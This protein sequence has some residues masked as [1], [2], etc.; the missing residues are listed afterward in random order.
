[1]LFYFAR[2]HIERDLP[3]LIPV[4]KLAQLFG[5]RVVKRERHV[6]AF[7]E[8][9]R[10]MTATT[11]PKGGRKNADV[12]MSERC[13]TLAA[14][15]E[16]LDGSTPLLQLDDGP[17]I[18]GDPVRN[19]DTRKVLPDLVKRFIYARKQAQ[20]IN[21]PDLTDS[22]CNTLPQDS[23]HKGPSKQPA[24]S[25]PKTRSQ[26]TAAAKPPHPVL[27][28]LNK[29]RTSC[30]QKTHSYLHNISAYRNKI[31]AVSTDPKEVI[32]A[33]DDDLKI[34]QIINEKMAKDGTLLYRVQWQDTLLQKRHFP[35]LE[36]H[37]HCGN[38]S[39]VDPKLYGSK[40]AALYWHVH[41]Q[42]TWSQR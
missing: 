24:I 15:T 27:A 1:M 7:N 41:W 12:P 28:L 6:E 35:L 29:S 40:V 9:T 17:S 23:P 34:A 26:T 13:L 32:A 14:I 4:S 11:R 39:R 36:K 8:L 37:G 21:E 31:K 16:L 42:D 19:D 22:T 30:P 38:Y 5:E 33:L 3:Y 20:K 2:V 10:I 18:E 25:R